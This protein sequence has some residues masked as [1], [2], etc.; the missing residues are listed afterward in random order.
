MSQFDREREV[1]RDCRCQLAIKQVR[2]RTQSPWEFPRSHVS[3]LC[4]LDCLKETECDR[5]CFPS[6]RPSPLRASNAKTYFIPV[7]NTHQGMA[8]QHTRE[9][10]GKR[11]YIV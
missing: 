11:H 7:M 4:F 6:I 10:P 2:K 1:E 8:R 5:S 9:R 3:F